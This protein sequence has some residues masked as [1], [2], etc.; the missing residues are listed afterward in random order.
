[1]PKPAGLLTL[2]SEILLH[3]TRYIDG[4]DCNA[5]AKKNIRDWRRA[6]VQFNRSRTL[7]NLILTCKGLAPIGREALLE[8]IVISRPRL[9]KFVDFLLQHPELLKRVTHIR[10]H[11]SGVCD[12][13]VDQAL[14][15]QAAFI[16][17]HPGVASQM[18]L[19]LLQTIAV[20]E[21]TDYMPLLL[22]IC[23]NLREI[24]L[25]ASCSTS[26]D[27][28]RYRSA[29]LLLFVCPSLFFNHWPSALTTEIRERITSLNIMQEDFL[30]AEIFRLIDLRILKNLKSLSL[31]F[32]N[33]GTQAIYPGWTQLYRM[34]EAKGVLP[35]SLQSLTLYVNYLGE[36]FLY[37]WLALLFVEESHLLGLVSVKLYTPTPLDQHYR[38]MKHLRGTSYI[39]ALR[40]TIGIWRHSAVKLQTFFLPVIDYD[41]GNLENYTEYDWL[42]HLA[43]ISQGKSLTEAIQS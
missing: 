40:N 43:A 18:L 10:V 27:V 32:L 13:V 25:G 4:K 12:R 15:K 42:M 11:S 31:P 37:E 39:S 34:N 26:K 5:E 20:R 35:Q 6:T 30:W 22:V 36:S 16:Q 7:R 2:P 14:L 23:K 38:S 28:D 19:R 41:S 8:N 21:Q 17:G 9:W 29:T 24:T 33:Q 3:I 1:M